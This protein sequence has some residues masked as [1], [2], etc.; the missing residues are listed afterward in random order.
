MVAIICLFSY[1][2]RSKGN[3]ICEL[4]EFSRNSPWKQGR[5]NTPVAYVISLRLFLTPFANPAA[6]CQASW[7][8]RDWSPPMW[9]SSQSKGSKTE[10]TLLNT[11]KTLKLMCKKWPCA[12]ISGMR[13]SYHQLLFY[14][15]ILNSAAGEGWGRATPKS[16]KNHTALW[17]LIHKESLFLMKPES[18]NLNEQGS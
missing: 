1:R 10:R 15:W 9:M 12:F 11:G 3:K 4:K 8:S 13:R 6:F 2:F 17:S 16:R 5:A 7:S 14:G 18:G